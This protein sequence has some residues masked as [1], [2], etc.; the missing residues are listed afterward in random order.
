MISICYPG[1]HAQGLS[2]QVG[3]IR[4]SWKYL[5]QKL[6]TKSEAICFSPSNYLASNKDSICSRIETLLKMNVK[7]GQNLCF[8][9]FLKMQFLLV[10]HQIPVLSQTGCINKRKLLKITN[11]FNLLFRQLETKIAVSSWV[12]QSQVDIAKC[13]Q[14]KI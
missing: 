13:P 1:L 7:Q 11:R 10:C 5:T 14:R 9:F 3:N 12:K 2:V 8:W 6:R 4:V